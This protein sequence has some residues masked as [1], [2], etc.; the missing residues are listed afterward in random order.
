VTDRRFR[1][2]TDADLDA[3]AWGSNAEPAVLDTLRTGQLGKH[4]LLL[5]GIVCIGRQAIPDAGPMLSENYELLATMERH[6]PAKIADV[7]GNPHVGA[8]AARCLRG[9]SA[10]S[11][12]GRSDI[13]YLTAIAAAA[14][15]RTG[16]ACTLSL[17]PRNGSVMLPTLGRAL[18]PDGNEAVLTVSGPMEAM[19]EAGGRSIVIGGNPE[20]DAT[21]WQGLRWLEFGDRRIPLDDLD[22]YRDYGQCR[23][24]DR[25]ARVDVDHWRQTVDEA[26][27]LLC[28][29]HPNYAV[30]LRSGVTSLV[31]IRLKAD[32][33]NVSATSGDAFAAVAAS[34]P[35]DGAALAL[36]LIHEFQH[37]KLCAA[38][39]AEPLFHRR[40]EQLFYAPWRS[41]PRPVGA[42]FHGIYAHMGVA[43]FWRVQRHVATGPARLIAEVEFARWLGQTTGAAVRLEGHGSLTEA[44]QHFLSQIVM[45]LNGWL[46]E[47][48]SS[49]ARELADITAEDH[50]ICWRL[51]NLA[52]DPEAVAG[53][54]QD[55]LAERPAPASVR[56]R[57]R[58]PQDDAGRSVRSELLYQRLCD[59]D[60][61]SART[62]GRHSDPDIAFVRGDRLGAVNGYLAQVRA[63][64]AAQDGWSGLA[65]TS[66]PGSVLRRCPEVVYSVHRQLSSVGAS[67]VDPSALTEWLT[68]MSAVGGPHV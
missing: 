67:P 51:R 55:W 44:G 14:A 45:R 59:P 48:V 32:Q 23:L 62:A 49:E 29:H 57:T 28:A 60:Q 66:E 5:R 31:P 8:W 17:R 2:L 6:D 54:A 1:I 63:D 22:P 40:D 26:W 47:P 18:L 43:D 42:L 50:L 58:P 38:V 9:L 52:P 25:L 10:G 68:P 12:S 3:L 35:S 53:I 4:K 61:F 46:G 65:L 64:P 11:P 56:V 15:V 27:H 36:A 30:T 16:H 13:H 37:A 41:D 33:K 39:D 19:I 34:R 24:A 21:G 7:I 20:E